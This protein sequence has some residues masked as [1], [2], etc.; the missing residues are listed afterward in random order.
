VKRKAIFCWSGGKDSSFALHQV[1]QQ[2]EYEIVSL[3]TTLNAV[4]RR[5]SMHGVR[6]VLLDQQAASIGLPLAKVW[7][8]EGTNDEYEREMGKTLAAFHAE[9]VACMIFGDIFLEDLRAYREEKLKG[10]GLHAMFPLWKKN[11]TTLAQAFIDKGFKTITCCISTRFLDQEFAGREINMEFIDML[12]ARID[13]CGENGEFHSFCYDGPIFSRPVLF[14]KGDTVFRQ[15]S[16]PGASET[17]G[18]WF[19]DLLPLDT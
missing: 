12:P 6:E 17:D 14:T 19:T 7:V 2:G 15:I 9:G 4:H 16:S 5:I 8:N 18:F 3:L 10:I 11:T 13:P 1:L